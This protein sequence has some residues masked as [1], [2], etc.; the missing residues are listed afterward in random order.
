MEKVVDIEDEIRIRILQ[1][2]DRGREREIHAILSE[3]YDHRLFIEIIDDE[4]ASKTEF[5]I[6]CVL[7]DNPCRAGKIESP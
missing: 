2:L 6:A 5:V 7:S 1:G 4:L 3:P